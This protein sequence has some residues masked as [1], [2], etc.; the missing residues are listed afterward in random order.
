MELYNKKCSESAWIMRILGLCRAD[1]SIKNNCEQTVFEKQ[2]AVSLFN[3]DDD[4]KNNLKK[5]C[6]GSKEIRGEK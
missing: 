2:N 4:Y 5:I 1:Q 6:T 3:A